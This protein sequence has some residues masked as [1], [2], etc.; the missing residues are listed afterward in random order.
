MTPVNAEAF[1][2]LLLRMPHRQLALAFDQRHIPRSATR[3][4][5]AFSGVALCRYAESTASRAARCGVDSWAEAEPA[6]RRFEA[7]S[8]G[9]R[10]EPRTELN[11]ST[12]RPEARRARSPGARKSIGW[13]SG[14]RRPCRPPARPPASARWRPP[15]ADRAESTGSGPGFKRSSVSGKPATPPCRLAEIRVHGPNLLPRAPFACRHRDRQA[16]GIH[17]LT[18]QVGTRS[19]IPSR[20]LGKAPDGSETTSRTRSGRRDRGCRSPR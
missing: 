4:D 6:K 16:P 7:W 3:S 11:V 19:F 5:L 20:G 9:A 17:R 1:A 15:A 18:A 2:L 12:T 10:A 8:G 13:A 14:R